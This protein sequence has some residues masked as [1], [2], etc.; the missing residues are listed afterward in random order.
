MR[1]S[2]A[3]C[4]TLLTALASAQKAPIQARRSSSDAS[5]VFKILQ[6]ADVHITG[7]PNVGCGKSVPSG[8]E[9]S[10]ALT[11][12]FIEQL[13]DL[14]APDFIAFTG[15]NVQA[16]TPSLQ[17]RAIDAVTKTAEER[18][19][20]YGMV[21]GNHDEEG[22]FPRA[23][24]VEMVSEKNHSYTESGPEDVDGI[25]NYMLNVTAPIA[26]PWGEAGDSVLRMYFLDSGHTL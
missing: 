20:P 5:L 25:G 14:E 15:D 9:C 13:V 23:K 3:W 11:Y 24:I 18:G 22:G 7:D 19:I 12:E 10:E 6:L 4:S 26:G 21:F 8:T 17:Q 1:L 2:L 16:W